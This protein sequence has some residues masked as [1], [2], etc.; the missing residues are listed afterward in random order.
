MIYNGQEVG[1]PTRLTFPFLTSSINWKLNPSMVA[2]YKKIISFR[3][4]SEAIRRGNLVTYSNADI[5]AF[6]KSSASETVFVLS[7]LRNSTITYILP[8]TIANT[9]WQDAYTGETV[10]LNAQVALSPYQYTVLKI[11][12]GTPATGI[13]V[14]FKKPVGWTNVSLYTWSPEVLGGWPGAALTE[15]N[16]W[17]S[18]TF[19]PSFTGANLIFNNGGAGEQTVDYTISTSTCLEASS[20]LTG[21]KYP[22]SVAACTTGVEDIK[23]P[24]QVIYPN[25]VIGKLHFTGSDMIDKITIHSMTGEVVLTAASLLENQVLDVSTLKPGV[26]FVSISYSNGKQQTSKFIKL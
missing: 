10:Q 15:T 20:T 25:P 23:L 22:V 5:C 17:Y 3:N 21:G 4:S 1:N 2:E 24:E 8:P 18:Y 26:Y 19:D 7:N 11:N 14:R 9:Q 6:T 16:G 13:T 12:Q